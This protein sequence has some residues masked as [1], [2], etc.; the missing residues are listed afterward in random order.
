M[1]KSDPSGYSA[2]FTDGTSPASDVLSDN[3]STFTPGIS[4]T[5]GVG[6]GQYASEFYLA[7]ASG[8]SRGLLNGS[9]G[10]TDGYNWDAFGTLMNRFGNNPT[11]Y[12][13]G[14]GSGYQTDNDTGLKLLGHRY[15]DGRIGRFI[16]QDPAGSGGNWYAYADNDPVNNTD[17]TGLVI[18]GG[19]W[20]GF[21]PDSSQSGV[22]Y[23]PSQDNTSDYLNGNAGTYNEY[24]NGAYQGTKTVGGLWDSMNN[25]MSGGSPGA[26]MIAQGF[27]PG[28]GHDY[29]HTGSLN[30][31]GNHVHQDNKNG[32]RFN[33]DGKHIDSSENPIKNS[34]QNIAR[35]YLKK[36]QDGF[37]REVRTLREE[38]V[39]EQ[40]DVKTFKTND[41][42]LRENGYNPNGSRTNPDGEGEGT[43]EAVP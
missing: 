8:N 5:K 31:H 14:E 12:A 21:V 20:G 13:W 22:P 1:T 24:I 35:R 16:S 29:H 11:G 30:E 6:G 37:D 17:P 38:I 26:G 25:P 19:G 43:F 2:Y 10:S 34:K 32:P 23:D 41:E 9:Q 33:R 40:Q 36:F 39:K 7:D 18:A 4:E 15:Y 27:N 42:Y 3:F 28:N